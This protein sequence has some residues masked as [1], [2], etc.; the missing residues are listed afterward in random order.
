[1]P[2]APDRVTADNALPYQRTPPVVI[3]TNGLQKT[4]F[5]KVKP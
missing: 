1:M 5:R 3:E 2:S 4:Y